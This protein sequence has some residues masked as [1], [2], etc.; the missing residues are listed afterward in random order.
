MGRHNDFDDTDED[1][2]EERASRS[3]AR[4]RRGGGIGDYL[5]FR[6]MIVPVVIQVIFWVLSGLV[7]LGGVGFLIF[8]LTQR[9][10][11]PIAGIAVLFIGV[12][13]YVFLI[14]VYCELLI[15]IFRMNDTLTDIKNAVE[16]Q[17]R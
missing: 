11:S 3:Y 17:S 16:R 5:A 6:K 4:K 13:F 1:E 9:G 10:G 2:E 8:N 14:R 12:P 7:V 15:V